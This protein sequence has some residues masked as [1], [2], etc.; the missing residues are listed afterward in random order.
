MLLDSTSPKRKPEV[1][2]TRI[3]RGRALA[4]P[5]KATTIASDVRRAISRSLIRNAAAEQLMS[6]LVRFAKLNP[7]DG[8]E[9]LVIVLSHQPTVPKIVF[10]ALR[11]PMAPSKS[12]RRAANWHSKYILYRWY[13]DHS[14]SAPAPICTK[15]ANREG[16]N[17][18][19]SCVP[20]N[21]VLRALNGITNETIAWSLHDMLIQ[22]S[23]HQ[24]N[25]WAETTW[26]K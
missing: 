22:T 9:K 12:L 7:L 26:H 18:N 6:E 24:C 1:I 14:S 15:P 21:T 2:S 8:R 17:G 19:S 11:L 4:N 13:I 20:E 25:V 16:S 5:R 3:S 23:S 10:P